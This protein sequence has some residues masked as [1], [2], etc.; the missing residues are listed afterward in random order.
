MALLYGRAGR[1]NTKNGGSRPGQYALIMGGV[2]Y[3][4]GWWTT[5]AAVAV[6][7]ATGFFVLPAMQVLIL[8]D[9]KH[10]SGL[11]AGVS[12]LVM[13]LISTGCSM[14][15]SNLYDASVEHDGSGS[16]GSGSEAEGGSWDHDQC[17]T[18]A[19]PLGLAPPQF[20][21]W[22]L[23]VFMIATQIVFWVG[24]VGCGKLCSFQTY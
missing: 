18:D 2:Y 13:T 8:E 24:Y 21:L 5:T 20:L 11:T 4:L 3:K 19:R 22:A 9:F 14:V 23:A 7:S 1:L 10:M 16:G 15:V 12:K 6:M 17:P